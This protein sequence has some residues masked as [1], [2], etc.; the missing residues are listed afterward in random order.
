MRKQQFNHDS[1]L[2][3]PFRHGKARRF[4][5]FR[6]GGRGTAATSPP[7]PPPRGTARGPPHR[8][9]IARTWPRDLAAREI[10]VLPLRPRFRRCHGRPAA[11]AAAAL[12]RRPRCVHRCV[13]PPEDLPTGH[14]SPEIR[15][16]TSRRARYL[17][18][19]SSLD[20]R[21]CHSRPA[22]SAA[23]APQRRPRRDLRRAEP[24]EDLP[25]GYKSPKIRPGT[26]RIRATTAPQYRHCVGATTTPLAPPSH[27]RHVAPPATLPASADQRN[28]S[29]MAT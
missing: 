7:Q 5:P 27:R 9:L 14:K 17:S 6:D 29:R 13:G 22:A 8:P 15:D 20:F 11:T 3:V 4:R 26:S 18:R 16:G 10:S 25:I 1:V 23:A 19:P 24:P 21:R 12:Q 28:S 2:I